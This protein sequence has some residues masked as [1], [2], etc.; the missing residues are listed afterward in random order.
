MIL[1]GIVFELGK[2]VGFL[3]AAVQF[4]FKLFRGKP[5]P[6]LQTFGFSLAE[7]YRQIIE[8]MTFRTEQKPYPWSPWPQ[9]T[10]ESLVPEMAAEPAGA[11]VKSTRKRGTRS[12]KKAPGD[13]EPE[14]TQTTE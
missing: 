3:V 5:H 7:F 8:F 6:Q 12:K 9:S 4:L 11:P 13:V 2:F 14:K 10:Q 1:Y